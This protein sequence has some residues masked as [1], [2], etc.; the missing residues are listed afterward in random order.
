MYL[1]GN[2]NLHKHLF[3]EYCFHVQRKM[4]SSMACTPY[5][6]RTFIYKIFKSFLT[7]IVQYMANDI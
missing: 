1:C 4:V 6:P 3:V 5:T 2:A 7:Y